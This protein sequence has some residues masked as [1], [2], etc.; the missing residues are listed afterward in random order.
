MGARSGAN[1]SYSHVE[2]VQQAAHT[3]R[4]KGWLR[5]ARVQCL[6]ACVT[7]A[8]FLL[9][10]VLYKVSQSLESDEAPSPNDL[11]KIAY[12]ARVYSQLATEG[13]E[14]PAP[15]TVPLLLE[16]TANREVV[17][18][19][20]YNTPGNGESNQLLPSNVHPHL[21]TH[22]NVAFARIVNKE[23]YL[24]NSQYETLRQIVTLKNLNPKLKIL[25]SVGGAGGDKGFPEMVVNHAARKVFI[26]S[27]KAILKN[28]TLDGIDLDW[29]FPA[30]YQRS[31]EESG[32]RE[33]Q[34]FSQLLREIRMEYIREKH[35][36][37]LTVAVPAP[38][39]L[40]D[41]SYDVDQ[42]NMYVDYVNIMTYD[43]H[44]Y[45][46]Y[47]PFTGLNSPLYPRPMEQFYL[48]SLNINYTVHMYL[49]KG[50]DKSKIVV[51]IPTYGHTFMLVNPDNPSIG[52][53]A[54]GF[55]SLG[56]MGFVNYPDVCMYL[57]GSGDGAQVVFD[58]A[59]RVPY[60][61]KDREWVSYDTPQSVMDKANYIKEKGLRGAMI[62]S[63]NADDYEGVCQ[64]GRWQE[65]SK[66]PLS[67][68]V[69]NT[70]IYN[71]TR[72]SRGRSRD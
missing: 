72:E 58:N 30:M 3:S 2:S 19:C 37:L 44:Y 64:E 43:F 63:L 1:Q 42:L 5:G 32:G 6:C 7:I 52:S 15:Q 34:H 8:F 33:R 39:T 36:Y 69:K 51:G 16:S 27:I 60:M 41:I 24:D 14:E 48:A 28:Y 49:N 62:Y 67:Q 55:G 57:R 20:Y 23:I 66:F 29:E 13:I 56:Q 50:L 11:E 35:N 53:P 54:S 17:V 59:T 22:I 9:T 61:Y 26:R 10:I 71:S 47:T 38:E 46:K 25:L 40:V 18:S 70:L 65:D 45:T 21:C 12:R 68:S 31:I 4:S